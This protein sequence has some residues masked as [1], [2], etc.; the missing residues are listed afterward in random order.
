MIKLTNEMVELLDNKV[1]YIVNKYSQ[2]YNREDLIQA[3]R[4]GIQKAADNYKEDFG[5]KFSTF[6]EKY[7]LGEI[8]KYIREDKNIRVSR[9]FI[10]LKKRI[11][12]ST[13]HFFMRMGRSPSILELSKLLDEDERKISEVLGFDQNV[14]SID[15]KIDNDSDLTLADTIKDDEKVD[16]ID[17]ISLNDALNDLTDED[18]Q[19]IKQRYYDGKTQTELASEMNISQVKVYRMERR[20]LDDLNDKLAA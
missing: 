6:C 4:L 20:I 15:I 7:I 5:V 1:S 14:R 3:G 19:I 12:I 11:D 9:D 8:L 17:L 16:K 13:E 2:G 10:R 18:R